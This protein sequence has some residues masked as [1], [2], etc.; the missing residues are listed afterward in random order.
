MN[1][2][3]SPV[4]RRSAHASLLVDGILTNPANPETRLSFRHT[5]IIQSSGEDANDKTV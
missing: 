1:P 4:I 2:A 3:P 5:N